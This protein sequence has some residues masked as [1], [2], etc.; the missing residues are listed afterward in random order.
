MAYD[1]STAEPSHLV[2]FEP[3]HAELLHPDVAVSQIAQATMGRFCVTAKLLHQ[4]PNRVKK[5]KK[6]L[7]ELNSDVPCDKAPQ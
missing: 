6:I 4:R 7:Y 3:K 1:S 2:V 5:T